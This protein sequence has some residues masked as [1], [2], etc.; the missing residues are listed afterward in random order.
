MAGVINY[1]CGFNVTHGFQT[2][3]TQGNVFAATQTNLGGPAPG[4]INALSTGQGTL[5]DFTAAPFSFVAPGLFRVTNLDTVNSLEVGIN[6]SGNITVFST[7]PAGHAIQV[8]AATGLAY[9]VRGL[10]ATV[11][12]KIEGLDR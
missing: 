6:V 4:F 8:W 11:K 1:N 7:V 12:C 2:Y 10:I 3:A 5:V 9:R